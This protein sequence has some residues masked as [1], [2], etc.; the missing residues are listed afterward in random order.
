M[1]KDND[2]GTMNILLLAGGAALAYWYVTSYGPTG[3]VSAG[4]V[5]WWNTW[6]GAAPAPASAPVVTPTPASPVLTQ[7]AQTVQPTA[8]SPQPVVTQP[9]AATPVIQIP[10]NFT[11]APDINNSL[12]GTVLYN[13][14]ATALNVI[15]GNVG[16][17]TGVV[18]NTQGEDITG[19]L[20]P[21]A[22]NQL[23]AAFQNQ[24]NAQQITGVSGIV[25]AFRATYNPGVSGTGAWAPSM[26]FGKG[27]GNGFSN[28]RKSTPPLRQLL[29]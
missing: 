16:N 11:V 21:S 29:N 20:G 8:V 22:V 13:G 28:R 17:P 4:S 7:P 26:S 19:I 14:Q 6:F 2:G 12:K 23:V 3:A 5:S 15:L 10:G 9:T 18:W 27:F 24:A 25:P 1:A